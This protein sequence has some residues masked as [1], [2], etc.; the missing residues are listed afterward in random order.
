MHYYT[1]KI[2]KFFWEV[3]MHG[4]SNGKRCRKK[5]MKGNQQ[6]LINVYICDKVSIYKKKQMIY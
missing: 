1:S 3:W 5:G 6:T 2:C 4:K